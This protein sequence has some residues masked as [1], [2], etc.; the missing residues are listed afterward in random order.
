VPTHNTNLRWQPSLRSQARIQAHGQ[1]DS[2]KRIRRAGGGSRLPLHSPL[3]RQPRQF[4][5]YSSGPLTRSRPVLS[6]TST[7]PAATSP[8]SASS[9]MNLRRSSLGSCASCGREPRALPCSS[10]P[11]GPLPTRLSHRSGLRLRPWGSKSK[12]ST[13]AAAAR[14]RAPLLRS[15]NVGL[16]RCSRGGRVLGVPTGADCRAGGPT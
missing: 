5:L 10:I 9:R 7:G 8:V 16:A 2:G 6:P 3:R 15:S 11:N 12:S 4:P 13:S 1:G 14:S